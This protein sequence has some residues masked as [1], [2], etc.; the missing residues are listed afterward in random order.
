MGTDA[1][2]TDASRNKC[3]FVVLP[4]SG[5]MLRI[6]AVK[7]EHSASMCVKKELKRDFALPAEADK[8]SLVY[9]VEE[10][11]LSVRIKIKESIYQVII[12]QYDMSSGTEKNQNEV[13]HYMPSLH[14]HLT[15]P[16][17]QQSFKSR[18]FKGPL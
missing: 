14:S 18:I 11:V 2:V 4:M 13:S 1:N 8:D 10:G 7:E 12:L 3:D 15:K 9:K 5:D 17:A 6:H 16:H